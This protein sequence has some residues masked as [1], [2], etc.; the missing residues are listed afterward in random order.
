[1]IT[2]IY[3]IALTVLYFVLSARVIFTRRGERIAYGDNDSPR[4][5][6]R[7]RAF[8]NLTEY[9]PIGLILLLLA[10]MQDITAIWLHVF[11]AV[12]TIGRVMHGLGMAFQPKAFH[13]RQ[14]GM[15][16]TLLAL[17]LGIVL[18]LV[19]LL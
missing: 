16:L 19:A 9:A 3:A 11:G 17:G 2:A 10:E 4:V 18:N 5:Q 1:M 14:N 12:F 7:I 8:G 15:L 6:A 13:W